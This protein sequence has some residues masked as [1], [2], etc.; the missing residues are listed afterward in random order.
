[1]VW[2]VVCFLI[3]KNS[4]RSSSIVDNVD[5]RLCWAVDK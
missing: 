3:Y 1:M 4:S 2:Q 5:L